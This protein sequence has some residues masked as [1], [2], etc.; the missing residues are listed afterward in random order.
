MSDIDERVLA[1]KINE[2]EFR[3]AIEN[4][5]NSLSDLEKALQFKGSDKGINDLD[6]AIKSVKFDSVSEAAAGVQKDV[7]KAT[8]SASK[9]M[10]DLGSSA[11]KMGAQIND[12]ASV[13][14]ASIGKIGT[15][16]SGI[17]NATDSIQSINKAAQNVD[18]SPINA[19][20]DKVNTDASSAASSI[21]NSVNAASG[22]MSSA[23]SNVSKLSVPISAALSGIAAGMTDIPDKAEEVKVGLSKLQMFTIGIFSSLASSALTYGQK[24]MNNMTDGIRSGFGDYEL[25]MGS[26]QTILANT[27][28]YGTTLDQ[29]NDSLNKLNTYADQTIYSFSDMTKAVGLFT[30]AG[31]NVKDATSDIKGFSNVA[32]A[33]GV[34]AQAAAG[35]QYQLSQALSA[36][37]VKLMD[38]NSLQNAGMGNKNMQEQ[39]IQLA[40]AMGSFKA[41]GMKA[42]DAT[43]DFRDSLK[44]GWLSA[45]VMSKY[46]KI[47][48]GDMSDA[49]MA[50]LHLSADQIK[51]FKASEKIANDAATK[52][53]TFSQMMGTYSE[54]IGSG[55]Q[56]TWTY[57]FGNFNEATEGWTAVSDKLSGMSNQSINARNAIFKAWHDKGG[58]KELFG[59]MTDAIDV[60]NSFL[61]PIKKGFAEVFHGDTAQSLYDFTKKI[62]EFVH[63]LILTEDQASKLQKVAH[64]VALAFKLVLTVVTAVVKAISGVLHIVGLLAK[65]LVDIISVI[66][67]AVNAVYQYAKSSGFIEK[68]GKA[69]TAALSGIAT[70]I[71]VVQGLVVAFLEGFNSGTSKGFEGFPDLLELAGDALVN[72]G[73]GVDNAGT[74]FKEA[75]D[76]KFGPAIDFAKKVSDKVQAILEG[77]R[78][79]FNWLGDKLK[80]LGNAIKTFFGDFNGDMTLNNILSM[81]NGGFLAILLS[82]LNKL[83]K[84]FLDGGKALKDDTISKG[85]K[86]I[87]SSVS[88][89]FKEFQNS[90]KVGQLVAIAAAI[91][92]LAGSLQMLSEIKPAKLAVGLAGLVS[93]MVVLAGMTTVMSALATFTNKVGKLRFDYSAVSRL[94]PA[95]VAFG[96]S[97]YLMAK[98]VSLLKGMDPK[99]VAASFGSMATI[100]VAL[101]ASIALMGKVDAKRMMAMSVALKGLAVGFIGIS[102]S[103]FI[104]AAAVAKIATIDAK[105]LNKSL[106]T[107]LILLGSMTAAMI[108]FGIASKFGASYDKMAASVVGMAG[109]I[110]ILAVAVK[111]LG[112]MKL[113]QMTQ[114]IVGIIG[115][116]V[117][118]GGVMTGMALM[119]GMGGSYEKMALSLMGMAVAL[120]MLVVPVALLGHMKLKNLAK[121]VG[122]ITVLMVVLA[123]SMSVLS[124][125]NGKYAGLLMTAGA[126]TAFAFAL[127]AMTIP[128][129]A[130]G[131]MDIKS[132]AE[133]LGSLAIMAGIMIAAFRLMPEKNLAKTAGAMFVF[134]AALT[135]LT[136][137]IKILSA[138]PTKN[139][140]S[141]LAGL[142]GTII[143]MRGAVT[144]LGSSIPVLMAFSKTMAVFGLG[145]L[146]LGTGVAL[147]AGGLIALGGAT[148]GVSTLLTATIDALIMAIPLLMN[149]IVNAID[150]SLKVLAAATP[151]ILRS[152]DSI[153]DDLV[154]YLV[155]EIP[156]LANAFVTMIDSVLEKVADHADSI[157]NSLVVIFVAALNAVAQHA[158]EITEAIGNV[159]G[160]IFEAIGSAIRN[161]DPSKIVDMILS[162]GLMAVL[163]HLMAK[164]KKDIVPALLVG[165]SILALMTGLVGV[166]ALMNALHVKDVLP[167]AIG[168][169]TLMLAFSVAFAVMGK[170]KKSVVP[171]LIVGTAMAVILAEFGLVFAM[172]SALHVDDVLPTATGLSEVLLALTAA[173]A[174]MTL[175]PIPA[176]LSAVASLGIVIGGIAAIVAAAGAISLIP[177]VDWLMDKGGQFLIKIGSAIGGFV[178]S[179]VSSFATQALSGLPQLADSLSEFMTKLGP[180]IT[181]A[182]S[183]NGTTLDGVNMLSDIVLKLTASNFLNAI[184]DFIT[185]GNSLDQ[186]GQQLA[187]LGTSLVNYG[188][189]VSGMNSAA[190]TQSAIAL[191]M[192]VGIQNS[193]PAIG[194]IA[195]AFTG[196]KDWSS[197][198]NGLVSMGH[199]LYDYGSAVSGIDTDA[200]TASIPSLAVLVKIQDTLSNTG[201]IFQW[202]TG[203]KD[204]GSLSS[205]LKSLGTALYGYGYS[206]SGL[207]ADAIAASVPSLKS[208]IAIQSTLDNS[209]GLTGLLFGDKS[210]S[211]FG[212]NVK[213]IGLALYDYYTSVNMVGWDVVDNSIGS[214]KR[215]S[216]VL[217]SMSSDY[218]AVPQF[219]NAVSQVSNI[220]FGALGSSM[221]SSADK[222]S[223]AITRLYNALTNGA[224]VLP[225]AVSALNGVLANSSF[226]NAMSD[227]MNRAASSVESGSSIISSSFGTLSSN[228]SNF[229]NTWSS[230]LSPIPESTSDILN[231]TAQSID[232][233]NSTFMTAGGDLIDALNRGFRSKIV[234]SADAIKSPL[235]GAIDSVNSYYDDFVNAGRWLVEGFI[236]GINDRIDSAAKAAAKMARSSYD[237]AMAATKSHSPSRMMRQAGRWFDDGYILGIKDK[238]SEAMDASSTL[239]LKSMEAFSAA[240]SSGSSATLSPTISPIFDMANAKRSIGTVTQA[241][242]IGATWNMST[243]NLDYVDYKASQIKDYSQSIV[244]SNTD[245]SKTISDLRNDMAKYTDAI[246]GQETVLSVDGRRLASTIAKPMNQ[247]LGTLQRRGQVR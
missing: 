162:M 209:G 80:Q 15:N 51:A 169:S 140:V 105:K 179:I 206:V 134:A 205:G 233:Y 229:A 10:S 40:D 103:I 144:I 78:P 234:S 224:K 168:L 214:L 68:V 11:N 227:S 3:A 118:L 14:D 50:A 9:D 150:G 246:N 221:N 199:A 82:N 247:E 47:M 151:S 219:I 164:M 22:S 58:T 52:V 133:G 175:I 149:S 196:V 12:A 7:N 1:L 19:A 69:W 101:G 147:L 241:R 215:L 216:S 132:L 208:L 109:A 146:A 141:G 167:N 65:S 66:Y 171:A 27:A 222:A 191:G 42:S 177:G 170:L 128:V 111:I 217:S 244:D 165:G 138:I 213:S 98:G 39:L 96:A 89:S 115:L 185:G 201:G 131:S 120:N 108:A 225:S 238:V 48:A 20:F 71:E 161:S 46:L 21:T 104:L 207:D 197:F 25:Q 148:A 240:L 180:F 2:S 99:L 184:T 218:G 232:S 76:K 26:T 67:D 155:T 74:K 239:G 88:D 188:N 70:M 116:L 16:T 112:S 245:V 192:L 35:A 160:A 55:W 81:V 181:G 110:A 91:G 32:A 117:A 182:Q 204:W 145:V 92:L 54:G 198:T 56:Q 60:I 30:N 13:A 59:T 57:V 77:L 8:A 43:N 113:S 228:I 100:I 93:I 121:G 31:I 28:R 139:L 203:D 173:I 124:K 94:A 107:I 24:I 84:G 153:L 45:D 87:L 226:A 200:I 230:R 152:I 90:L 231:I 62:H 237:A 158:P 49:D 223:D 190:V 4:V 143:I 61:N 125:I 183:L 41:V 85:I 194:G 34:S 17:Q 186:F 137:P 5:I 211:T 95:M 63:S 129:K 236:Q 126:I 235:N 33:S 202:F 242:T 23:A 79:A 130:L 157:A 154:A 119:E 72:F 172:M 36:G 75:V 106:Q 6:K 193:L 212:Q 159:L 189:I 176:A 29:V 195:Q 73:N 187:G 18:L 83:V 122:A 53:R 64:V 37:S 210:F 142:M 127:T 123:G 97:I 156:D 136:I 174:V 163:F 114:G 243:P 178:G 135:A 166:F 220:N 86:K 102:A 38:W 44:E